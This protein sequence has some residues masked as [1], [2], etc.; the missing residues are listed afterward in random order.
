MI[1][2]PWPT[3]DRRRARRIHLDDDDTSARGLVEHR[4][5]QD[6]EQPVGIAP[7]W[8]EGDGCTDDGRKRQGGATM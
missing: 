3:L 5:T 8:R 1:P 2:W 6:I 4:V 7:D